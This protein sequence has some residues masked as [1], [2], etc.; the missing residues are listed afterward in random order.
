MFTKKCRIIHSKKGFTLIELIVVIAIL[1]ILAAVLIPQ[2]TGFQ[3][4]AEATQALVDAKQVATAIDGFQI[5]NGAYP[6]SAVA[7]EVTEIANISGVTSGTPGF[8]ID[9]GKGGGFKVTTAEGHEAGRADGTSE[10]E[11]ELINY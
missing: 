2:F 7:A 10:V 9:A 11:I 5:E 4:K 8:V 1:G 6:D 3:A